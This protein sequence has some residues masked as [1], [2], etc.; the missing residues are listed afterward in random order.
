MSLTW[1]TDH[2]AI[3][4]LHSYRPNLPSGE[5]DIV[6]DLAYINEHANRG[7]Q[8]REMRETRDE[9]GTT[10]IEIGLYD[11][12]EDVDGCTTYR[13]FSALSNTLQVSSRKK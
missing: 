2:V 7:L 13:T 12:E 4:E 1:I 9:H 10:H 3:G 5:F 8:H 6:V 11:S